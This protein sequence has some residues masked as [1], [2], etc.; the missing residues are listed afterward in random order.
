[1]A[2]A[3]VTG[4]AG[5]IGSHLVERLL[6]D[7]H[8]VTVLD[9]LSTGTRENLAHLAHREGL[10]LVEGDLRSAQALR[11]SLP[12][13]EVV[14]HVAAVP[15]VA[16]SWQDPVLSLSVNAI[17][18]ATVVE[19]AE[20]AGVPALVYSSSSSIY[21]EQ[22]A[23]RKSEDL[24]PKPISPYG[25]AKLLGEKIALAHARPGGMR[26]LALRYFNVF[27]P[28]QDPSS[29]YSA[30]IPL[31]IGHALAGS[32]A[33]IHGDGRQSRD[34]TYVSNVVDANLLAWRSQASGLAL[35]IACGAAHSLLDLV[36]RIG[37]LA[38]TPIKIEHG[39][40]RPGDIRHSLADL[41]L[42]E[43]SIGYRPGIT[44]AQGL[45]LTYAARRPA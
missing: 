38:G 26:V 11:A 17:G 6:E 14:F 45:E 36:E 1:M 43:R 33:T 29:P 3:V 39:E 35:N 12:G 30:V 37:A 24:V 41:T 9:D 31:F 25:A 40:P 15:S 44:F 18:T 13:A 4:G 21:G 19:E 5:F 23:E 8:D 10:E 2:R 16:R 28:R 22:E 7:G 32:V 20:R 27:G 42:A 34:F